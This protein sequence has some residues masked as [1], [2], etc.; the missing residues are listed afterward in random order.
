MQS[1]T[2]TQRDR[3][4]RV[5][6]YRV[7]AD[8][9]YLFYLWLRHAAPATADVLAARLW[10]TLGM[11]TCECRIASRLTMAFAMRL[12]HLRCALTLC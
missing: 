6:L 10:R 1:W 3:P 8:R 2:L 9:F 4:E 12:S 11:P 5:E 7:Y